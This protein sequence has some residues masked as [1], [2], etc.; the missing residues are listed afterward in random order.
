MTLFFDGLQRG[1]G[2]V[3]QRDL[4]GVQDH[5]DHA[6]VTS[7]R[8]SIQYAGTAKEFSRLFKDGIARRAIRKRLFRQQM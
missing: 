5:G 4:C 2:T 8:Q 1:G 3:R 6:V 7:Q